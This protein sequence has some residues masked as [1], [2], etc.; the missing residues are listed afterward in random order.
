VSAANPCADHPL[1]QRVRQTIES[2]HL[3]QP[4]ETVLA[5]VSG[6]VDSMVLLQVLQRLGY[7]VEVA[8]FDHQTRDGASG[9]DAAFL[10]EHCKVQGIPF[11]CRSEAVESKAAA[12]GLSFEYFARERRYAFFVKTAKE[13]QINVIATGHQQDDQAETT[14]MGLL[15]LA[16][17]IGPGGLPPLSARESCRIIR[18][19]FSCPR[20]MVIAWAEQEKLSWR[21]DL[22]NRESIYLRNKIRLEMMPLLKEYV[23]DIVARLAQAGAYYRNCSSFLDQQASAFLKRVMKEEGIHRP[24]PIID[25]NRFLKEPEILRLHSLKLMAYRHGVTISFAHGLRGDAFIKDAAP[26]K[27][28]DLGEGLRLY[29]ARDGVHVVA[30]RDRREDCPDRPVLLNVPGITGFNTFSIEAQVLEI[31]ALSAVHI[32]AKASASLQFFDF[33]ALTAPLTLRSRRPGDHMIPFGQGRP[34]KVK[35][36][37]IDSGIPEYERDLL[38]LFVAGDEILW[39]VGS[40]RSAHAPV[41]G[42]TLKVLQLECRYELRAED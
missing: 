28:F 37:L 8:H 40:R 32:R 16:S 20:E 30:P 17:H 34:K 9:L 35:R 10:R 4:G 29:R 2:Y 36:L 22:S 26:G 27:Y 25:R 42:E 1:L 7:P 38:P 39:I 19:L 23:P 11:H 18:P 21:E 15:G 3:L 14:L 33:D 13:Q 24:V 31:H 5:A 41:S 12:E 6:G